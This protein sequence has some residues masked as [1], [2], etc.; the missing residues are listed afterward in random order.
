MTLK[1]G[2]GQACAACKYQ[3][4]RCA[5]DCPLAPFFPADQPKMFQNAHKLFGVSNILKILKQLD[6]S[7]KVIAMKSIKYQANMRD[8]YPVY[9]C[10]VEIQQLYY[11]IQMAEEELHAT[12]NQLAYYRQRHQQ[13]EISSANESLSRLQLGMAPPGNAMTI[14]NQDNPPQ[15]DAVTA[16]P[17]TYSNNDNPCYNT[18]YLEAKENNVVDSLWIQQPYSNGNNSMA[19]QSQL[20]NSQHL[21]VQQERA[22]DYDEIYPFF[23]TIDDRQSYMDSK[24]VY[25]SSSESSLKDTRQSVDQIAEN[26]LKS[27][28][29]CFSLTSVN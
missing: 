5:S 19:M 12:L 10:L 18:E 20:S 14:I 6:P 26:E 11:Q 27:A 23:D 8:K 22:Q 28:A 1:G 9:G 21:S 3:R 17:I 2:T 25:E 15:Y 16:L 4:R 7:Q 13:Q 24:E 29:A